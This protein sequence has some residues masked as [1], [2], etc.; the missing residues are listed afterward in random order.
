[1]DHVYK[2]LWFVMSIPIGYVFFL[3]SSVCN[4]VPNFRDIYL[5]GSKSVY[6]VY[7]GLIPVN[8]DE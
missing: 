7:S 1:M 8:F 6:C 2:V 3:R 4:K 5:E